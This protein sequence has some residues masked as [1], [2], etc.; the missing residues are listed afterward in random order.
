MI[1]SVAFVNVGNNYVRLQ[2][3]TCPGLAKLLNYAEKLAAD[4]IYKGIHC[5]WRSWQVY[6]G[7]L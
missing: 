5:I 1:T 7:I 6:K 2:N 4:T 3:H